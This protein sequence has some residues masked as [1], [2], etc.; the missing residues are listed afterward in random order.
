[1]IFTEYLAI[2]SLIPNVEHLIFSHCS[3]RD[4]KELNLHKL[5]K[6]QYQHRGGVIIRDTFFDI[7]N[8][9]LVGVLR[10]L[11]LVTHIFSD[12]EN[13]FLRQPNIKKL[14]IFSN[15]LNKPDSV[16]LLDNPQLESFEII[17][18]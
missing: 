10:E 8:R 16:P 1:M 18:L 5:R 3:F 9:L 7:F 4:N 13:L 6:L 15:G 17:F 12:S 11:E 14:K 2:L